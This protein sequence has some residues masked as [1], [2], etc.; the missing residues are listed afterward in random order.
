V[1]AQNLDK[2]AEFVGLK[3]T[4]HTLLAPEVLF[5]RYTRINRTAQRLTRQLPDD[6]L[7]ESAVHNR[8]RPIRNL[9]HHI[10]SIG[11]AHLSC[12]I[13]GAQY[14]PNFT[15]KRFARDA[16]T[17]SAALADYG[18][19]VLTEM[20]K[21]WSENPGKSWRQQMIDTFYG[22]ISLHQLLERTTWHTAQHTRQLAAVLE[23]F[24]IAPDAP[25]T[26]EDLAGLPVPERIWE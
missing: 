21:W 18:Q 20:Q 9:C 22:P 3:G 16:F 8:E 25:L 1:N 15:S 5:D 12:A 7:Q 10:F 6:K 13:N 2:V 11:E 17:S 26:S 14:A 24:D 23:R 19:Q 4:S